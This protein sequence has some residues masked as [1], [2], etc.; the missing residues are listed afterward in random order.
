MRWK[1][2]WNSC[3][4]NGNHSFTLDLYDDCYRLRSGTLDVAIG[5]AETVGNALIRWADAALFDQ[6]T[7]RPLDQ[8]DDYYSPPA[9]KRAIKKLHARLQGEYDSAYGKNGMGAGWLCSALK[10][11]ATARCGEGKVAMMSGTT[12]AGGGWGEQQSGA[13]A[14]TGTRSCIN[15]APE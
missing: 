10:K 3:Y 11:G 15:F 1:Q 5:D 14:V 2:F 8:P 7:N 9:N 13:S 6:W 4:E 12:N